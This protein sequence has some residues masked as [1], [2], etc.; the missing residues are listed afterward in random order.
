MASA[1]IGSGS[2]SSGNRAG[3]TATRLVEQVRNQTGRLADQGLARIT[4]LA[5]GRKDDVSQKLDAVVEIVRELADEVDGRFGS[6]VGAAVH[7]SGDAVETA[8]QS[9]RS[10]SVTDMLDGTRSAVSRHPGLAIGAASILG[11]VAG[12][13]VKGGLGHAA[14]GPHPYQLKLKPE[15]AA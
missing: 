1:E 6:V 4:A 10:H 8:A 11:F 15:A 7:R 9:L 12:R 2:G 14:G 3:G 5:E 13:I